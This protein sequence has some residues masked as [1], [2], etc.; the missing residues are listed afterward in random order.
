MQRC[1]QSGAAH[2]T[3]Y[4]PVSQ[5]TRII[6]FLRNPRSKAK[7]FYLRRRAPSLLVLKM[8]K[9]EEQTLTSKRPGGTISYIK[10]QS[11]RLVKYRYIYAGR[12]RAR[13]KEALIKYSKSSLIREQPLYIQ[14]DTYTDIARFGKRNRYIRTRSNAAL[15]C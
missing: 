3:Y 8:K 6:I 1:L 13:R 15:I 4:T 10:G 12:A 7:R 11:W 2:S 9:K 5:I 14:R